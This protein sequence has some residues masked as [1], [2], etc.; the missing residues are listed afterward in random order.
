[1]AY[2]DK[3][4]VFASTPGIRP[5][6]DLLVNEVPTHIIKNIFVRYP[7]RIEQLS[8]LFRELRKYLSDYDKLTDIKASLFYKSLY[9][10]TV[11]KLKCI[12]KKSIDD[13]TYQ[14][15]QDIPPDE[16]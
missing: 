16:T 15:M 10:S 14:Y 7:A 4:P 13:D 5:L 9:G 3:E 8:L 1:M 6:A 11:F 12:D 2:N